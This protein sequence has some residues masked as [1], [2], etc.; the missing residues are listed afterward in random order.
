MPKIRLVTVVSVDRSRAIPKSITRG[1]SGESITLA[2]LKSRWTTPAW[3]MAANA[4]AVPIA[5]RCSRAPVIGPA[6]RT[7][8]CSDGPSMY[9]LTT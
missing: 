9:S 5:I 2:G 1:P 3:W 8:C 4:V 7:C 6:W